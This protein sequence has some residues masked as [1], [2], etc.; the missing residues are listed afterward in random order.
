MSLKD[1]ADSVGVAATAD[2]IMGII[3]LE[4]HAEQDQALCTQLKNRYSSIF[5]ENH[6]FYLGYSRE[7]SQFFDTEQPDDD[8]DTPTFDKGNFGSRMSEE[9]EN[10]VFSSIVWS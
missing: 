7:K 5:G 1:I 4:E 9:K 3:S 6:K 10:D 8:E 2:F